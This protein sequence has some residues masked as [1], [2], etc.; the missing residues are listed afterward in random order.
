MELETRHDLPNC[1]GWIDGTHV[2]LDE[3]P[4]IDKD[5]YYDKKKVSLLRR[6]DSY[7]SINISN[8]TSMVF[9]AELQPTGSSHRR[10]QKTYTTF[11]SRISRKR[12][13]LPSLERKQPLKKSD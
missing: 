4:K 6:L 9:I 13:R 7:V 8:S 5:S 1:V 12:P 11:Y 10:S 3:A 2:N